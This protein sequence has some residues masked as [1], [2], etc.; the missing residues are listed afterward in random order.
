[1]PEI[2]VG[3]IVGRKSY[4]KDLYFKVRELYRN[5]DGRVMAVLCGLLVRLIADAPLD[6]LEKLPPDVVA[7]HWRETMVN[8]GERI[9]RCFERREQEQIRSLSRQDVATFDVPGQVLHLD[10]DP[11]YLELCMT[12]YKQLGVP[13]DG[14]H[15][16][17]NKQPKEVY[18]LLEKHRPNILVLTGHDAYTKGKTD[19][20]NMDNYRN[21]RHFVEAVREARRFEKNLDDLVIFAGACQSYYEAILEAGANF[22][23]SPERVLIHAFDPVFIV[24]KL[25]YTPV[26]RSIGLKEVIEATITGYPGIGGLET[27][28]LH[29]IGAP[30]SAY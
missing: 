6:D 8:Q 12:T 11:D 13:H 1:M 20:R 14:Y 22:A 9:K 19:F 26:H 7:A 17:E 24:E 5:D 3:D 16:P 28:G 21:S 27:R 29:R 4:N 25:A 10:G 15:I 2:A 30:R 18:G 23:S